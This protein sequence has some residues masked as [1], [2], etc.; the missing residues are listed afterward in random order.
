MIAYV[1]EQGAKVSAESERLIVTKDD[2][3][4]GEIETVRCDGLLL[5]GGVEITTPAIVLCARTNVPVSFLTESGSRL[6]AR[7]LPIG[8]PSR[9]KRQYKLLENEAKC[10][11]LSKDVISLK[12]DNQ[13]QLV[14]EM[15]RNIDLKPENYETKIN[16]L[17]SLKLS[18]DEVQS[19]NE[20]LGVEGSGS[21]VYFGL[22]DYLLK[23]I[24]FAGRSGRN[25]TDPVNAMLNLAYS[26]VI[27]ELSAHLDAVGLDPSVGFLHV[28]RAGRPSLALDL[29]EPLRPA[30]ADH[31]V[32]TLLNRRE[33]DPV[34]DF[35]ETE[36]GL[37]LNRLAFKKFLAKWEANQQKEA[38]DAENWDLSIKNA[39]DRFLNIVLQYQLLA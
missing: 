5:F 21:K 11:E 4:L 31:F 13:R 23:S 10:I 39:V 34:S 15:F 26:L 3:V 32:I 29:I 8:A 9:Y 38:P 22:W 17:E 30:L 18:V 12:L 33:I 16:E 2:E 6:K 27:S 7:I 28:E 14:Y 35:E 25:A 20:L 37:R 19:K 1:I 24:T 36:S